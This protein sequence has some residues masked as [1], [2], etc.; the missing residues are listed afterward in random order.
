ML[1]VPKYALVTENKDILFNEN[2]LA[3]CKSCV[4]CPS[5]LHKDHKVFVVLCEPVHHE[6]TLRFQ[7][8]NL[9]FNA[10]FSG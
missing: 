2:I 7:P 8:P 5:T 1:S 10:D 9:Y 6:Y 3:S 4:Q